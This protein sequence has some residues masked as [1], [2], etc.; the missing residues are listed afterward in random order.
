LRS[1]E[2]I[3]VVGCGAVTQSFYVPALK[4]LPECR[5]EFFVD[6]NL[7]NAERAAKQYGR[8]EAATDYKSL[9][10]KVDGAIIAVP[11][12][13]HSVVS[14]DFLTAGRHV[15]CEK[16]I[17]NN[18]ENAKRM[19]EASKQSGS[20]L[21]VNLFRRRFKSYQIL[22]DLLNRSFVGKISRI[23]Y[24]EGVTVPWQFS[25]SYL[26]R[27]EKSGGGVLIDWGAHSIDTLEWLFGN[28]WELLSYR[29]DGLGRIESSCTL[30]FIINWAE[31]RIPCHMELS[32]ARNL[33]RKMVLEADSCKLN[34]D[35]FKS[36]NAIHLQTKRDNLTIS[37]GFE[38]RP[39]SNAAYVTEQVRSF[40]N[41]TR[42][43][44]LAG[45]D[46][47]SG[48]QFIEEC[49][50]K[51]EDLTQSWAEMSSYL[52]KIPWRPE[53]ILIVGASG[54]LGSRLAEILSLGFGLKVRGTY[55]RPENARRIARLPIELT[56]CDVLDRTRVSQV[57][58]GCDVL[59][60]CAVGTSSDSDLAK[61]VY[62]QGT[63][64]LLEAAKLHR[65][66]KFVHI[67]TAAVHNFRQGKSE[68][69]ESSA[70]RS[71]L[72]RNSYEKGKIAQERIVRRFASSVP[73][74]ILRPTIIYG[75]YSNPWVINIADRLKD[76][77]PTL[78]EGDGI[79]NLVYVDDVVDAILLAIERDEANGSIMILNNDKETVYWSDYVSKFVNLT[80]TAPNVLPRGP[81]AIV[82][83]R[84]F[85]SL[86]RDSA[87]ASID[88]LT[89][90]EM[91]ALLAR[92]PLV[93]A[94][95]SKIVRG[96]KREGVEESLLSAGETQISDLRKRMAK[97]ETM[98]R[99][100]HENLACR[101]KFSSA[102]ATAVCGWTPRTSF[103]QGSRKIIEYAQW[104]GLG[105]E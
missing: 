18:V 16:P 91:F 97:Y 100:Q 58:E 74:V 49:Y 36:T 28:D 21:S 33:G 90:R 34:V 13:L 52:P 32:Y 98:I 10:D 1:I 41:G 27:K 78:V 20:R 42:D 62:V 47:L 7:S 67:S 26:L 61:Q 4:Q 12:D 31:T 84:K 104:A 8:G 82:R 54:F 40:V 88:A 29:D 68:I 89:S 95:G 6:T 101:S 19:I 48:I 17:A 38:S 66:R 44:C 43:D 9:I 70:Y 60:N 53:K 75:P 72:D 87:S 24:Q 55:H 105:S 51:R 80:G 65:V 71:L 30:D 37:D 59:V 35:E 50:K 23:D 92:I 81:L 14:T 63:Q 11:N 102:L 93:V 85:L 99:E 57:V 76:G 39:K 22:K 79:A 64:N 103:E 83:L 3:A 56:E 77:S 15:L 94:V 86:C 69:N 73:I 46:A 2:K 25:S 45:E 96:A 5:A